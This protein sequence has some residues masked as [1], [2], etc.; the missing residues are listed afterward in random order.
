MMKNFNLILM[1]EKLNKKKEIKD[2][3]QIIYLNKNKFM[4]EMNLWQ[5]SHGWEQLK[6]Q[7]ITNHK[8]NP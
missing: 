5:S 3:I 1:K 2:K 7:A 4:K 6:S 8:D